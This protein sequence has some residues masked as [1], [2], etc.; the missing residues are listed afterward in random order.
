[1]S[2]SERKDLQYKLK[3]KTMIKGGPTKAKNSSETVIQNSY[4]VKLI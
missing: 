1:M 3:A 2:L 4:G